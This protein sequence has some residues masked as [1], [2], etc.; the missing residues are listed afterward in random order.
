MMSDESSQLA[1]QIVRRYDALES[2]QG[3]FRTRWQEAADYILPRKGNISRLTSSGQQQTVDIYDSTPTESA[4]VFAAGLISNLVPAGEIWA[5]LKPRK[6]SSAAVKQW[7]DACTERE[8]EFIYA[9]NFYNEVHEAFM[10]LGVFN[11]ACLTVE[12]SDHSPFNFSTLPVGRYVIAE[13]ADGVV[14]TVYYKFEHTARQAQ[15]EFGE[16]DLGKAVMA[17]LADKSPEAQDRKFWFIHAI[18]PRRKGEYREGPAEPSLRPVASCYV[19]VADKVV[20]KEDGYYELPNF[21]CRLQKSTGELYGRGPGLDAMPEIKLLNRM[22][23]NLLLALEAAV[24]PQWL[25]PDDSAYKPDNRPS[26]ITYWDAANSNNRPER[27]KNES[28]IDLGEQKTAQKRDRIQRAFYVQMFQMLSNLETMKREKTAFEVAQL[29]QEKLVLFAPFFSRIVK[30]MLTPM[31]V[32][33]FGIMARGGMFEPPPFE[34]QMSG[35]IDF[36][37]DYV[38]K[39]ALAIKAAQDNALAQMIALGVEIAQFDPSA[40]MVVKWREAMRLSARNKGLPVELIRDDEEIDA[41]VE[42]QNRAAQMEPA[43]KAGG[44]MARAAKDLGPEAQRAMREQ[45]GVN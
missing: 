37:I 34:I 27:L 12:E 21:V 5:K 11:T 8:M 7:F 9:S 17:A 32:R 31:L 39:I 4:E 22:E 1:E 14:D 33:V 24:N 36:E 29:L 15:E 16:G 3:S 19:N 45:V 40:M 44:M 10:D 35:E 25:M 42:A 23:K 18:Y 41:M 6:G 28:R 13:N 2:A 38:S 43:A 20:V 30:E 26:G